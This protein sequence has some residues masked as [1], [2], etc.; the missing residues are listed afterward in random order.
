M[1]RTALQPTWLADTPTIERDKLFDYIGKRGLESL[2]IFILLEVN[3]INAN[4]SSR[5]RI[6]L[7]RQYI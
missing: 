3:I 6:Y 2:T 5:G 1:K 4:D 7:V